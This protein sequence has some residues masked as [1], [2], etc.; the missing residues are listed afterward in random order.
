MFVELRLLLKVKWKQHH[1]L[2][3]KI[4]YKLILHAEGL[5]LEEE[6]KGSLI[7][8]MTTKVVEMR[9]YSN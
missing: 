4:V 2:Y 1:I 9:R 7:K 8:E 5:K 3:K 6:E